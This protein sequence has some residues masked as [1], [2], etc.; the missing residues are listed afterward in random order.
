MSKIKLGF[1][2][3]GSFC[4]FSKSLEQIKFLKEKEYDIYPIFSEFAYKTD[5]RFYKAEEYVRE[6]EK[7]CG[8]K[9]IHTI[10]DAEPIG[11]KKM[12]DIMIIAPC[13]GNTLSKL[14]LGITDT[15]VTMAAKAHLRNDRPLIIGVSS[16]DSLSTSAKNIGVLLSRRNVYFVPFGQ[17][18]SKN[19]PRSMVCDFTKIPQTVESAFK[20]EQIQ[21]MIINS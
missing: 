12:L 13:T 20:G 11:P 21:P 2:L 8:K 15:S 18:D 3:S 6:V 7:I 16:N 9:A 14:A 10:S 17:D 5:T 4:T 1:A 19:K